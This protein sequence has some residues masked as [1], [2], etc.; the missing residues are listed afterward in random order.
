[1]MVVAMAVVVAFVL[2]LA[3]TAA[4]GVTGSVY[5][6]FE[7]DGTNA[8]DDLSTADLTYVGGSRSSS[9]PTN[10]IPNPDTG[11]FDDTS[12]P[13]DNTYSVNQPRFHRPNTGILQMN[14]TNSW[15]LEGWFQNGAGTSN[16]STFEVLCGTRQANIHGDNYG[17]FLFMQTDRK[18]GLYMQSSTTNSGNQYSTN[19]FADDAWHH[20][21]LVYPGTGGNVKVYVDGEVEIDTP[22]LAGDLAA[23]GRS[24]G[25]GARAA[26]DSNWDDNAWGTS[27]GNDARFDEWRWTNQQM[28]TPGQFLN[29]VDAGVVPEPASL[30]LLGLAALG[31]RLGRRRG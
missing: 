24:F 14:G 28:L 21:A 23:G 27:S 16:L 22:A 4:A 13:K 10:P 30:G 31:L 7:E 26:N 8:I 15:T 5:W 11:A 3:G 19:A 18:L 9:I 12:D 6:Q 29:F 2:T 1:M 25:V 20:F 17:W